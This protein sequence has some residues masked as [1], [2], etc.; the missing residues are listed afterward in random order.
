ME[1][2]K[3]GLA[4]MSKAN[5]D[6][7]D[8]IKI[9]KSVGFDAF[10]TMWTPDR[11]EEIANEAA[12]LGLFQQSIHSPFSGIYKVS[13]MWNG[14]DEGTFV[15]NA[16]IDCVNDCSRFDIP[17]MVIHPFI[18]FREHTPTEIG[19]DNYSRIVEVANKLGIKL[20]FENVEGEE[21]L[22]ALM[23]KFW[24]EECC[25]FCLDTG[26]EQCYNGGKDMMA[27]YGQKLCHTHFNDNL[28]IIFPDAPID[29][30]WRND[31][32][33]VMGDGI[34]DWKNVMDRIDASPYEG[35]LI[36]ELTRSNKPGRHD[37]D[38]YAA[39]DIEDFYAFALQRAKMVIDRKL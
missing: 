11:T 14:G 4:T 9:F 12:K 32:H 36:C 35:I 27:L 16:L 3:L 34:V 21:Y 22:A 1:Q 5:V 6:V 28:G 38:G 13:H 25:G 26:H 24:D 20:G 29:S 23:D 10:F 18:G 37:H 8:Q 2:H 19:L 31:L 7:I 39:M 15:T 33:L 17:V 30:T